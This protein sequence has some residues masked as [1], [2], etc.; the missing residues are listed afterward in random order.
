MNSTRLA[1]TISAGLGAATALLIE[2]Y[3]FQRGERKL[4]PP[5][6]Y[7]LGVATLGTAFTWW[8]QR[9]DMDEAALAFWAIA[10]IGGA[11]T[12]AAYLIDE[13]TTIQ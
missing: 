2:H 7:I 8:A 11:A 12:T 13:A 5:V 10:G 3:A 9:H 6:T 1:S 4:E